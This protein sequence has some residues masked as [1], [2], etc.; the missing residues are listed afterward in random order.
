MLT[1][2]V[3]LLLLLPLLLLLQ[4]FVSKGFTNVKNVTGGIAA[5]SMIDPSVP[6]Y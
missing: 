5:Y 6:E 3:L 1:A 2:V 4:F